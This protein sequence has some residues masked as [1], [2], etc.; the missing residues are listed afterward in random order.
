MKRKI[1]AIADLHLAIGVPAK[2]MEVF[3]EHWL[4]YMDKIAQNWQKNVDKE[5]L[6][7]LPGD[8]SW[9]MKL[10][11]AK[12]DLDW[13]DRLPGTKV[14]IKGNHD[15][16]WESAGKVSKILPPSCHIIQN[17]AFDW[18]AVSIAGSRLWDTTEYNFDSIFGKTSPTEEKKREDE[19]V[20]AREL[21]RLESSLKSLRHDAKVKIAMTHYPPIGL[22][23]ETSKVSQLFEKYG[24]S[25]V[26]FG[27][28]HNMERAISFFGEKNGISYIL[29]AADYLN[30]TPFQIFEKSE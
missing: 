27:H 22:S 23:L 9:A 19:K 18:E 12:I 1:W 24:V 6:V 14:M 15:Y 4:G 26:V 11:E 16:W 7:L 8:I 5:D 13:I 25:I 20:F 28:L 30:F 2:T 21:L 10:A 29:V 3:G 17:N